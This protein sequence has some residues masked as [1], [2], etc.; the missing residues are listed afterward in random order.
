[1]QNTR[2]ELWHFVQCSPN[3]RLILC[4]QIQSKGCLRFL[5][6]WCKQWFSMVSN[7]EN[8]VQINVN[9]GSARMYVRTSVDSDFSE[10]Y[11]SNSLKLYTKIRYD[12]RIM[13]VKEIFDIIQNGGLAA[14]LDV[15]TFGAVTQP[16][17][18]GFL[19]NLVQRE[20]LGWPTCMPIYFL[21]NLK[22]GDMAVIFVFFTPM[23]TLFWFISRKLCKIGD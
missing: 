20:S 21:F 7:S 2:H 19:S 3:G 6:P 9:L 4:S 1:M 13:H 11:G 23:I 22:T 17:P 16:T 10:V 5:P 12:L 14:I 18:T 8:S 15:N